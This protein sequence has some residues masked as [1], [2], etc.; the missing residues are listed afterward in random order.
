MSNYITICEIIENRTKY[1]GCLWIILY[2]VD[3]LLHMKIIDSFYTIFVR[4]R[5]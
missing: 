1:Y 4:D 5:M 2:V 3:S